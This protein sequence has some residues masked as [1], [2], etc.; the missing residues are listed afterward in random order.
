MLTSEITPAANRSSAAGEPISG[1]T[2]ERILTVAMLCYTAG[3]GD[4]FA[5]SGIDRSDPGPTKP[6]LVAIKIFL[7]ALTFVAIGVR[8]RTF[9]RGLWAI[10]WLWPLILLPAASAFWSQDR[11]LTITSS[12]VLL[13]SIAFAV[14]F[15]A[16]YRVPEQVRL[17]AWACYA[18]VTASYLCAVIL[19]A[20]GLEHEDYAGAWKGVF[21]QKNNLA[22]LSAL[23]VLAFLFLTPMRSLS[24][25][26]W[27][28]S[29]FALLLM[30][31][32]ATGL[33]V[34]C[35]LIAIQPLFKLRFARVTLVVASVCG[36]GLFI[37]VALLLAKTYTS[38]LF[39]LIEQR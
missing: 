23:A 21:G 38:E 33:L 9:M 14:Y 24:R 26:F 19:P 10:K 15:G 1:S 37:M 31:K 6:A 20:Y 36:T 5:R 28:S 3:A 39:H 25:V 12:S 17:L 30:S 7:Y 34:C 27:M 8:W 11:S 18:M 13:A 16:R 29:A 32:S 22:E 2:P 35:T 4:A